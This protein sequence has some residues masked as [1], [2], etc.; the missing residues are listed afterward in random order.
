MDKVLSAVHQFN[1]KSVDPRAH[2]RVVPSKHTSWYLCELR[3]CSEHTVWG[4]CVVYGDHML[5]RVENTG[6]QGGS[7]TFGLGE[8]D[9]AWEA[10]EEMRKEETECDDHLLAWELEDW[11]SAGYPCRIVHDEIQ[12]PP[13]LE[14]SP[15]CLW[16]VEC[17]PPRAPG[18]NV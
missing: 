5:V 6:P 15:E 12:K 7:E 9:A 8:L 10:L 3:L 1:R 11:V 17:M 13:A 4:E 2:F 16:G 14:F 18:L